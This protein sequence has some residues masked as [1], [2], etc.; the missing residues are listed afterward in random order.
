MMTLDYVQ[1]PG[2]GW[3]GADINQLRQYGLTDKVSRYS[4]QDGDLVWLEEDCDAPLFVAALNRAGVQF[5]IVETHTRGDAWI[6]RL[7]SFKG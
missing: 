7:Q 4:Y 1:D 3:I 6:R 5:R 2:H